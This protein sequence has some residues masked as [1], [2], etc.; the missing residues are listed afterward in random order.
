MRR[1]RPVLAI[2][3]NVTQLVFID[4]ADSEIWGERLN[5]AKPLLDDAIRAVGRI[6][7]DRRAARLGRHR[8]A[9]G[10]ERHRHQPSRGA[11]NSPTA[12]ATAS[13]SR[14][15][16]T[17]RLRRTSISC[18]RSTSPTRLVFQARQAAAHR[19]CTGTRRR[20]LRDR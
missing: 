19:G 15:A 14:W 9:R 11:A 20:L 17:G 10:R 2:K 4:E 16:S 6:E 1:E 8:L 12:E 13:R 5:K 7:P 18:R 3:E